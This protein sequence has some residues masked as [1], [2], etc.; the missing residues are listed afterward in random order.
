[1]PSLD[2]FTQEIRI[3]SNNTTGLGYQA[4]VFSFEEDLDIESFD[5]PAPDSTDTWAIATQRQDSK[6][7]GIFGSLNYKFD[8]GLTLQ[9][10]A[11]WNHDKRRMTAARPVDDRPFFPGF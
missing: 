5:C 8:N 6:A 2:Q 7:L 3:A 1:V 11:R 4:G 10:G 9:A